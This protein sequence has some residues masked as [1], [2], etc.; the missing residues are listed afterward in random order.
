MG[1]SDP[2]ISF[3]REG[4]PSMSLGLVQITPQYFQMTLVHMGVVQNMRT[5]LGSEDDLH[6][7]PQCGK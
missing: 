4:V 1:H 3:F 7:L 2:G 6:W 5:F